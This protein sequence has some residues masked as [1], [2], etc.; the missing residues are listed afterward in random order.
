MFL[1]LPALQPGTSY[2]GYAALISEYGLK[3]PL[4][5]SLCAIGM[6]HRVVR[7]GYWQLYTPRH[8]PDNNL[9]GHLTFALKY[10]GIDLHIFKAL[11]DAI[12]PGQIIAIV[13][14][15][16]TG[17]YSRRV[18]FLYEWL[19]ESKLD[20]EDA[21]KGN[22]VPLLHE[23]LQYT[24][25]PRNSSRHRVRN[26]LPGTAQFCPLIRRTEKLDNFIAMNLSQLAAD[27]IGKTR[28]DLLDR[29]VASLLLKDSRASF[30]I[31]GEKP[32]H[33][34]IVDW[35]RIIDKVGQRTLDIEELSHLQFLLMADN[36]Y[37][38]IGPR[39]EGGFIGDHDRTTGMPLPVHISARP[40]DLGNL[41]EGLIEAYKLLVESNYNPVL[42]TALIAFGFV[43]IHPFEDGNGRIHRYLIHH[44]L[45]ETRFV[46]KD[47]VF[48]VSAVILERI[49]DYRRTL[50]HY[51]KP[52][53]RHIEW[54]ITNRGNIDVQNET[55]NLYRFFDATNQAEFLFECIEE[56]VKKTFPLEV[57]NLRKVELWNLTI[58]NAINMSGK[59]SDLLLRFL[60]Q[61]KGR[62]S[63]RALNREFSTLTHKEI[64]YIES[65]YDQIFNDSVE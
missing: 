31:E 26:N 35:S 33:Q 53:L 54:R 65:L 10:E 4:P 56:T 16:P 47:F 39:H 17:S 51:S 24:A 29:A 60:H 22:Y 61:N 14:T 43:F 46:P 30:D 6:K 44:M 34:S 48:P 42:A 36:P 63:K 13:N 50:E 32:P 27:Q 38:S 8:K 3:V 12:E 55:I 59:T 7:Q 9:H 58:N 52:R 15:Q 40:D 2:A 20:L 37:A 62:F 25:K 1:T 57:D 5:D 18:W 23:K 49:N 45:T 64:E 19:T 41:L 28:N 21:I 11:F